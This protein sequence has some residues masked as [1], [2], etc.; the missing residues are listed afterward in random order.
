MSVDIATKISGEN[1]I[2]YNRSN[3]RQV[4]IATYIL[5]TKLYDLTISP[6]YACPHGIALVIED[7][8]IEVCSHIAAAIAEYNEQ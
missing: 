7:V 4:A 5:G 6:H 8:T 3:D 1:I 2:F